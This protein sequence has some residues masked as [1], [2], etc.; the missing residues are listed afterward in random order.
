M[1]ENEKNYLILQNLDL[2]KI[3]SKTKTY[4]GIYLEEIESAA[5]LAL[6][7][8]ARQYK[9]EFNVPFRA[10]ACNK[11]K[12]AIKDYLREIAWGSRKGFNKKPEFLEDFSDYFHYSN[13]DNSLD[14][15][16]IIKPLPVRYQSFIRLYYEENLSVYEISKIKNISE[17]R[18]YQIIKESLI[19]LKSFWENSLKIYAA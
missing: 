12:W 1:N 14:F 18:V 10:Y 6:V 4:S 7:E 16:I 8:S 9:E 17:N 3:I 2:P 5:N 19:R 11:I 15:S 13:D